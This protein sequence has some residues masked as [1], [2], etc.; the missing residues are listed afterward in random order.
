MKKPKNKKKAAKDTNPP[1]VKEMKER[2]A[3]VRPA[4]LE[5]AKKKQGNANNNSVIPKSQT[6]GVGETQETMGVTK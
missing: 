1:I 5:K 4:D 2:G 3:I 6:P